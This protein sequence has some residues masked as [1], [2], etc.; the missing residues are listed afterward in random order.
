MEATGAPQAVADEFMR[1]TGHD[2]NAAVAAFLDEAGSAGMAAD[3][4]AADPPSYAYVGAGGGG[5]VADDAE[6]A[7]DKLLAQAKPPPP[8]ARAEGEPGTKPAAPAP[9]SGRGYTLAGGGTDDAGESSTTR[10]AAAHHGGPSAGADLGTSRSLELTFYANGFVVVV[11]DD[12][13]G[14][15]S[16]PEFFAFADAGNKAMMET[17]VEGRVPQPIAE[18]L[19]PSGTRPPPRSDAPVPIVVTDARPAEYEPPPPPAYVAFSGSGQTLGGSASVGTAA[20]AAMDATPGNAASLV[21]LITGLLSSIWA[22]VAALLAPQA[23]PLQPG[24]TSSAARTP[25]HQEAAQPASPL[26]QPALPL[27][28]GEVVQMRVAAPSRPGP[29]VTIRMD[30]E[31]DTVNGLFAAVALAM[32]SEVSSDFRLSV[33]FPPTTLQPSDTPLGEV[34]PS[35]KGASIRILE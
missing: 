11:V 14:D 13:G 10:P 18:R 33:G 4:D 17:L 34:E 15:K 8:G 21:G 5:F 24:G 16:E 1:R 35:L 32:Q 2:V 27:P 3:G 20:A 19:Y 12:G 28:A 26:V 23:G 22:S 30:A 31:R 6:A 25:P 9:F 7:V 29:P